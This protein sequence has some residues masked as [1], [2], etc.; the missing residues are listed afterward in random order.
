M[1]E[2]RLRV[3]CPGCGAELPSYSRL[4]RLAWQR[5]LFPRSRRYRCEGCGRVTLI[6]D[7]PRYIEKQVAELRVRKTRSIK[8]VTG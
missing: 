7:F 6:R 5:W 1:N 3:I 2:M 4:R 8:P